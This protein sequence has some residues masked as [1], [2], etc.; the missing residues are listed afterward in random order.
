MKTQ[1]K[2]NFEY[3]YLSLP[4][5]FYSLVRPSVLLTPEI[6]LINDGLC[7][8]LNISKKYLED[9][10][11]TL[12]NSKSEEQYFAQAYAGHQFG[13][14]TILGDGRA[15]ILG[16]HLTQKNQRFDIQLKGSGRTV[17]SRGGD[18]KATLKS[19]LREYIISE[20]MY[21]LK[22]PTSRSLALI[23]TG[24]PVYRETINEGAALIRVMKSHI[25]VGSFEYAA[26]LG[27]DK[28]LKS[29]TDYTIERLYPEI[30]KD[31]NPALSLLNK[32]IETQIN[33]VVQWLRVGFIHGVMNTDNTSISGETFDYGPCAFM[34]SYNPDTVFSSIDENGRYAFAN[35]AKIIK[36]NLVR[37]AEALLPIIHKD[38]KK[39]LELAQETFENFDNLWSEN[40]YGTMLNKIGIEKQHQEHYG[41][42]DE[43][44]NLMQNNQMDYTNTFLS[45]L[46]DKIKQKSLNKYPDF[47]L[48]YHKWRK[49]IDNKMDIKHAKNIMQKNNPVIIPRNHLVEQSLDEAVNGNSTLF[50][51]FLN[52][53]SKPYE[54]HDNLEE[55][56]IPSELSF[57]KTYKTFCGT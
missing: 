8:E 7:D 18:G 40:Y 5:K 45:L 21:H 14:F 17:Y 50:Q 46:Y 44:L 6:F 41:L 38:T 28:E 19:M 32:L 22:I 29:L 51:K 31:E 54:Y 47:K 43:L 27:F 2:F 3:S 33:L 48:W 37:F 4:D 26:H 52:T 24:E 30:K 23:K 9:F 56:M 15:T 12:G 16:E 10:I 36:W 13:Y 57:E 25:R 39:A 1:S 55:Y 53:L 35:Q 49:I 20:A 11:S 34:N 42:V